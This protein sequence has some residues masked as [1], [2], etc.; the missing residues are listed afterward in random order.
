MKDQKWLIINQAQIKGFKCI[1]R[2]AWDFFMDANRK[3]Y[4]GCRILLRGLVREL[5][6]FRFVNFKTKELAAN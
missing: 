5:A 3:N 4:N 2:V 6:D 1:E